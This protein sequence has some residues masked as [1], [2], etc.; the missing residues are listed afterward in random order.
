MNRIILEE[1]ERI[2]DS[3]FCLDNRKSNHIL[4]TLKSQIGDKLKAG[5]L[6][7][8]IGTTIIQSIDY[9]NRKSKSSW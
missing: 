7:Q 5:L 8:S 2:G 3:L 6:N 9:E 1:T 4:K